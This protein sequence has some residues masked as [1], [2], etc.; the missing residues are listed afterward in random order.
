MKYSVKKITKVQK[1]KIVDLILEKYNLYE[2][3]AYI[4]GTCVKIF[5]NNISI[6]QM[7]NNNFFS[8]LEK[9]R[10]HGRIFV[11]ND[12]GPMSVMYEPHS[13]T[14][15]IKN[16]TYYGIIKSIALA[17]VADFYE[18]FVSEHRRNSIH[19]SYL[20]HAGRGIGIIGP[21]G[22]GK[23]TLTYGLLMD[24][25]YNFLTDDWFF[26]RDY[27]SEM[28]V[29]A[30]EKNSYLREGLEKDWPHF[31]DK[32]SQMSADFEH[33][34]TIIDVKS[35]FGSGRIKSSSVLR[36]VVILTR[37]KKLKYPFKKLTPK[38]AV[39]FMVDN[40]YCNPHQ[41]IRNKDKY[42]QRTQ[43]YEDL[44]SKIPVYL[45]NTVETPKQ[46]INHLKKIMN[47]L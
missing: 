5:T 23:T 42:A 31:K 14:V 36:G 28:C 19:G 15:I 38:Q 32:L 16:C 33:K 9:I 2:D 39:K 40:D 3:K 35:L 44:F 12:S 37:N 4:N 27:D 1:N 29:Y 17:L 20:D 25:E 24:K 10:P 46:S 7:W 26:V 22:S 8:M 45:L 47:W 21:S 13:K 30:S 18:D 43:F 11:I 41:L 6:Y 34:R